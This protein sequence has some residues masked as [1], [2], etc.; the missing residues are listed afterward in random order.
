MSAPPNSGE[1]LVAAFNAVAKSRAQAAAVIHGTCTWSYEELN[2]RA[3][4]I[5]RHQ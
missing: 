4:Q 5:A 2:R 3:N 1:T